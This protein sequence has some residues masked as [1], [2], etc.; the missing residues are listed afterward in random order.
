[1]SGNRSRR[2]G[3]R[4]EKE[5]REILELN[6]YEYQWNSRVG[7]GA[8][9]IVGQFALEAKRV[10]VHPQ[11]PLASW[12]E[13]ADSNADINHVP[14]VVWRGNNHPWHMWWML[15]GRPAVALF[16]PWVECGMPMYRRM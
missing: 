14:V 7:E 15:D 5:V 3:W 12:I 6:G 2:K 16:Q 10:K 9:I 1:M 4:G 11:W 8:D 13:Q